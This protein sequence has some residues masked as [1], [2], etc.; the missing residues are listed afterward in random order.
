VQTAGGPR[1]KRTS[2]P[3]VEYLTRPAHS[4]EV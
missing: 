3:K 4:A 1:A 2:D